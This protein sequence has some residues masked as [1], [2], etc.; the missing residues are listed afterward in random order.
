MSEHAATDAQM[1]LW[2]ADRAQLGDPTHNVRAAFR[3]EGLV[4]VDALRHAVS[5]VVATYPAL[6][7]H[8]QMRGDRVV[9]VIRDD[10]MP[11]LEVIDIP[12]GT[13]DPEGRD[14][15][16]ENLAAAAHQRK[17]DLERGPLF[18][19]MLIRS[20]DDLS[21]LTLTF[22]HII[23]DGWSLSVV[24]R[25]LSRA[26]KVGADSDHRSNAD[27]RGRAY[28]E[29][30][31]DS[32]RLQEEA[33]GEVHWRGVLERPDDE[34][35]MPFAGRVDRG[36]SGQTRAAEVRTSLAGAPWEAITRLSKAFNVT[37]FVVVM[38]AFKLLIKEYAGSDR[39]TVGTPFSGRTLDGSQ[40]E[41]GFFVNNLAVA[42]EFGGLETFEDL[43]RREKDSVL[44][45]LEFSDYPLSKLVL[46]MP[47][48]GARRL[49]IY[50]YWLAFHNV[51][52]SALKMRGLVASKMDV[53]K[54]TAWNDLAF[55]FS[56]EHG[57]WTLKCVYS[58]DMFA[59]A[60][61]HRLV[62]A[63]IF[64]L[65]SAAARPSSRLAELP[66][67]DADEY[68]KLVWRWNDTHVV[69]DGG[70]SVYDLFR[71][72]ARRNPTGVAVLSDGEFVT[73]AELDAACARVAQ[74]LGQLGIGS[75]A[76][77]GICM[78]RSVALISTI[79]GVLKA[80]AAYVPLDHTYP[81][82]RLTQIVED[83][84][85]SLVVV[86][87]RG[88]RVAFD[89][90]TRVIRH[91]DLLAPPNDVLPVDRSDAAR[92]PPDSALV[93]YTSGSTGR[94][95][96]AINTHL[97]LVNRLRWFWHAVP[98]SEDEVV[99]AKTSISFVDG[100]TELL[101]PLVEGV[102]L[103]LAPAD[104]GGNTRLFLQVIHQHRVTRLTLV[105]SLL[106]VLLQ[107]DVAWLRSLRICVSSG[108]R[109][110]RELIDRFHRLLPDCRL[111]NFYGCS[112]ASGD[113][114]W[115]ELARGEM[116]DLIGRPIANTAVYILDTYRR[117]VPIGVPGEVYIGGLGVALGYLHQEELT[118]TRFVANPLGIDSATPP[119]L[120]R[121]YRTG[122][123]GRWAE[124]GLIE[125][126]GR[127]DDQVKI[128]GHRVEL[129]E[130][131]SA[132]ASLPGVSEAHAAVLQDAFGATIVGYVAGAL[133]L[134]EA[135]SLKALRRAY[136]EQLVPAAV[137]QVNTFPRL[138]NGKIDRGALP[139]PTK[140]EL[141]DAQVPPQTQEEQ[142]LCDVLALLL[143][144]ER[145]APTDDF[146]VLGGHSLIANILSTKIQDAYGIAFDA[147]DILSRPGVRELGI[148]I[149]RRVAQ[150]PGEAAAPIAGMSVQRAQE[151]GAARSTTGGANRTASAG[152]R[153][154]WLLHAAYPRG[155]VAD[156]WK[157]TLANWLQGPLSTELL[158]QSL[159]DLMRR[160]ELLRSE[161]RMVSD[162]LVLVTKAHV[163]VPLSFVDLTTV[164]D[165]ERPAM[166]AEAMRAACQR[167]LDMARAPLW[168]CQV[169]QSAPGRWM[170]ILE[171]HHSIADGW[172]I[173]VFVRELSDVYSARFNATEPNLQPLSVTFAEL[174]GRQAQVI[175]GA[176]ADVV[177]AYWKDLLSELPV[178]IGLPL[179]HERPARRTFEGG[180]VAREW[181]LSLLSDLR[182]LA[183]RK[184][185]SPFAI[186]LAVSTA[187]LWHRSGQRDQ[188]VRVPIADR[189]SP[190]THHVFGPLFSYLVVR[191]LIDPLNAFAFLAQ[192]VAEALVNGAS[193][194]DVPFET[195]FERVH[196]GKDMAD[197]PALDVQVV[198]HQVEPRR[199]AL[200]GMQA[201][202]VHPEPHT[203]ELDLFIEF[204]DDG[205]SFRCYVN[206]NSDV[207]RRDTAV[208]LLDDLRVILHSAIDEFEQ[209]ILLMLD[210]STHADIQAAAVE[211]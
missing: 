135:E 127:R 193:H 106:D 31:A 22:H 74:G 207:F 198:F 121:V 52:D 64:L 129:R 42:T 201:S 58:S 110:P 194:R 29:L 108:E 211:R 170:L 112:E 105:P 60:A 118:A 119:H 27:V 90:R 11:V 202:V 2:H 87:E 130:V 50:R 14:E 12:L 25:T 113:S 1:V 185:L 172:S 139:P 96:G 184:R 81:H 73:Y 206:Y 44:R 69:W 190:E 7:A 54:A 192:A 26:Y 15:E 100:T 120:T 102:A 146:F 107:E 160:H 162:D 57:A 30:L 141:G 186:L 150:A 122:D 34:S 66:L 138:P 75:G 166:L 51:P 4:D 16:M 111:L 43:L 94:P 83:A 159:S 5:E 137:V 18:D 47:T 125:F 38:A 103:A 128:R 62:R 8:F 17:F 183:G 140:R 205:E 63:Y 13:E 40:D 165:L 117:P 204:V 80:G 55:D 56:H 188:S 89:G 203:S 48:R 46:R 20:R 158:T 109:L 169:I 191:T 104:I 82:Q 187:L 161:F 72:C 33:E 181:P 176:R 101:A 196:P 153:R 175:S 114:T 168:H 149:A 164:A 208:R 156:A 71:E 209:P 143:R 68:E 98:A 6:R 163:E 124:D 152:Q 99:L 41:V 142:F 151:L 116:R 136:P 177:T 37:P 21:V 70:R 85:P 95:K 10:V 91:A 197:F 171:F 93:V 182:A 53:P 86:D 28:G 174:A 180:R 157:I 126:L 65:L 148:E 79:L 19:F 173:G 97:A 133:Q 88:G 123:F 84:R 67:V 145:V 115:A 3:L 92:L 76:L 77:V 9:Q 195:A 144:M 45:A 132:L 155:V 35:Q 59:P 61:V 39:V 23:A 24:V 178:T 200:A 210:A 147:H 189:A 78:A 131:E 154:D 167:P 36:T 49:S 134:D 179:D 199:L 32:I